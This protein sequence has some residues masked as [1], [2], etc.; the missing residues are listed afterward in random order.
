MVSLELLLVRGSVRN[1]QNTKKCEQVKV[2]EIYL[3][4]IG[5][6]YLTKKISSC[7]QGDSIT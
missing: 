7:E 2:K 4:G 1:E 5:G 3:D 6:A